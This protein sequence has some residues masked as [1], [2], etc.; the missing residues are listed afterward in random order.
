MISRFKEEYNPKSVVVNL[1]K[2]KFSG[3]DFEDIGFRHLADTPPN[4]T[5]SKRKDKMSN[6]LLLAGGY[7][8]S[9]FDSMIESGWGPVYDCGYSIFVYHE[10]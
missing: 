9:D 10:T 6:I 8:K 1:D 7:R 4:C 3:D 5:W 2:A